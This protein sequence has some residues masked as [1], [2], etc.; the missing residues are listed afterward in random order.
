MTKS[1][2]YIRGYAVMDS[3]ESHAKTECRMYD[4]R[5]DALKEAVRRIKKLK[6][7]SKSQRAVWEADLDAIGFVSV[8]AED[9][10]TDMVFTI[11]VVTLYA[12]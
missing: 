1:T 2:K 3:L 6:V 9:G 5:D 8:V 4:G 11:R 10:F 12:N 7:G